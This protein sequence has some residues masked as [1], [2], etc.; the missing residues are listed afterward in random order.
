MGSIDGPL[1]VSDEE[2][3]QFIATIDWTAIEDFA[4]AEED[5]D[6]DFVQW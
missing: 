4:N 1:H 3:E 2:V 5:S 6:E